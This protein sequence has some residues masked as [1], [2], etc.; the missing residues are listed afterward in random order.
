MA[1]KDVPVSPLAPKRQP[2]VPP[3]PGVRFATA[4][5]GIRYKGRTDVMLALMDEAVVAGTFTRSA[6]RSAPVR[7]CQRKLALSEGGPAA[8]LV[9]SGNSNAFT[10]RVGE[11][12]AVLVDGAALNRRIRPQLPGH[13]RG[14]TVGSRSPV[15]VICTPTA[16][17]WRHWRVKCSLP[18]R[19]WPR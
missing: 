15:A 13:G 19:N 14:P 6:T 11:E 1:G 5:A 12:V 7:D 18:S 3:I 17:C 8:F 16:R 9:N 10:G 2:K 4:E